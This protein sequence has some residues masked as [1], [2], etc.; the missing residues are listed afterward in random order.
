MC[1]SSFL[2]VGS[3]WHRRGNRVPQ[4]VYHKISEYPWLDL[5]EEI[6]CLREIA[7]LKW[8]LHVWFEHHPMFPESL[9]NSGLINFSN[10]GTLETP[11]LQ[12]SIYRDVSVC[13]YHFLKPASL[14]CTTFHIGSLNIAERIHLCPDTPAFHTTILLFMIL[15]Y[16]DVIPS[17]CLENEFTLIL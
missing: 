8:I 17:S 10:C 1:S 11:I 5:Q 2:E 14:S 12:Y 4:S 7:K 9:K 16:W 3:K 13:L 15:F 6:Q